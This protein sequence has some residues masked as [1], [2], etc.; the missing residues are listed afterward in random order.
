ME[1]LSF[2]DVSYLLFT[3]DKWTNDISGESC[4]VWSFVFVQRMI[5]VLLRYTL[6]CYQMSL[7]LFSA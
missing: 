4:L 5:S 7:S 6:N 2:V 3:G 1:L